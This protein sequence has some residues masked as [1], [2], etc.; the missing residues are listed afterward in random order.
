MEKERTTIPRQEAPKENLEVVLS[1]IM[2][3]KE[4]ATRQHETPY[5]FALKGAGKELRYFG[6][7]HERDP[8]NPLFQEIETAFKE[9]RPDIIFVEGINVQEDLDRFNEQVRNATPE[10]VIERLGESGFILKLGLEK[11]IE[12]RSPEPTD[13]ELY[14]FLLTQGFSKDQIFA[15]DVFQILP[16]YQRQVNKLSF[17]EYIA[18]FIDRFQQATGWEGFDYSYEHAIRLGEQILGQSIDVEDEPTAQDFIDPIP[19]EEKKDK[20]TVLNRIGEA[21]SLFRDRQIVSEIADALTTHKRIFIVYGASHAVMQEPAL[22][23]LSL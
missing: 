6:A 3:A 15:W 2:T 21:S 5:V 4:Y 19:W 23:K 22:R 20:Q 18:G 14:N 12:W 9:A 11:G 7:P 10:M 17:K 1:N 8:K 13:E 16:Q